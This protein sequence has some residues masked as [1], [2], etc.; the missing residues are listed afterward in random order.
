MKKLLS[1]ILTAA[2][3]LGICCAPAAAYS[4]VAADAWYAGAVEFCAEQGL[5]DGMGGD[6]FD[7]AG[8]VTRAQLV[9]T[10]WRLAGKPAGAG[11]SAFADVAADAWYAAAVDWA[12]SDGVTDGMGDGTFAPDAPLTREMLVTFLHRFAG[13]PAAAETPD[14]ADAAD[15]AD[16]AKAAAAWARSAGLV[17]GKGEGVFDPRGGASRAELATVLQNYAAIAAAALVP[18]ESVLGVYVFGDSATPTDVA[19]DDSG[20]LLVT[21][22]FYK[23]IW[24]IT[25]DD[26]AVFAGAVTPA[27]AQGEPYGGY[28][29][30]AAEKALFGSPR[31]L[32]PFMEGWAVSD[33]ANN[34]VRFIKDGQVQ[35]LNGID[36]D[37][38]TGLAAGDDGVLYVANTGAGTVLKV[39][40][41]GESSVVVSGLDGPTGLAFADGTLYVAETDGGNVW[42]FSADGSGKTLVSG[43]FFGPTGLAVGDD[44]TV[45]VADTAAAAVWAVSPD[46]TLTAL[47]TATEG[48]DL[49]IW[50]AAP[51]GLFLY[52][53][54]LLVCDRFAG[55]LVVLDL[56]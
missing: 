34:T 2:L 43:E 49:E 32:A 17:Q 33:P 50:P 39:T 12:V 35:T 8:A 4:D 13:Q 16:W 45:Y 56:G 37:Q 19:V 31:D 26:E 3:A 18:A 55:V 42:R 24:S 22:G 25:A 30:G 11:D 53:G 14:F 52:E 27:D 38:P 5:M 10:L 9:T 40:P 29:D 46:G 44:G 1:I 36:F 47:M 7:P 54:T 15:I 48:R 21:D 6:V 28:L 23:V 41:K 20:A 51:A